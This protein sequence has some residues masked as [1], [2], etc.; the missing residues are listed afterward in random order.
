MQRLRGSSVQNPWVL[1]DRNRLKLAHPQRNKTK[2]DPL[3]HPHDE[4]PPVPELRINKGPPSRIG[5]TSPD[6]WPD[7]WAS[8]SVPSAAG[9]VR[10]ET[11][12]RS[13]RDETHQLMQG[14][15]QS[16][17]TVA[18][19]PPP[20]LHN[21]A[22]REEPL[23]ASALYIGN[24]RPPVLATPKP[25]HVCGLCRDVKSHPVSY[26]CGHS[27]CFVCVRVWLEKHWT[28]PECAQVMY[29]APFRHHGEESSIRFDYPWWMDTSQVTYSFEGVPFPHRAPVV[30]QN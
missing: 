9:P 17:P 20:G 18:T 22:R 13:A 28:C 21:G 3:D 19:P 26:L 27:H 30:F 14:E 10:T 16:S 29:T 25:H 2:P 4:D 12:I 6:P 8:M 7:R 11:S 24:A 15:R 1:D 5:R 23:T